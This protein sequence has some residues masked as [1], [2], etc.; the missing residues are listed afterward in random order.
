MLIV[1]VA[2]VN[3]RLVEQCDRVLFEPARRLGQALALD[4][5][6]VGRGVLALLAHA[7]REDDRARDVRE[8]GARRREELAPDV[9]V[10]LELRELL[11]VVVGDERV[12][13]VGEHLTCHEE[14]A[15][16]ADDAAEGL[17]QTLAVELGPLEQLRPLGRRLERRDLCTAREIGRDQSRPWELV[18]DAGRSRE[19]IT[20]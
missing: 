20:P 12:H 10:A 9:Q 14:P 19:V 13:P 17:E 16:D 6:G 2:L 4:D 8:G 5:L 11:G 1:P 18:L 15:S 3:A 7:E